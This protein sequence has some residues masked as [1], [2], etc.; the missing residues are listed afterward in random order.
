M[1][2]DTI[3]PPRFAPVT[4]SWLE[5]THLQKCMY[6]QD[7]FVQCYGE[8]HFNYKPTNALIYISIKTLKIAPTCFDPL[9]HPQGFPRYVAHDAQPSQLHTQHRTFTQPDMLPQNAVYRK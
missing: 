1:T 5:R 2:P 4:A 9:D 8:F 7:I 3:P 6:V